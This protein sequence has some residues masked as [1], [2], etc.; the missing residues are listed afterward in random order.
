MA[1][2]GDINVTGKLPRQLEE[3]LEDKFRDGY[4]VSPS[5]SVQIRTF[6]PFFVRGAVRAPG[7]FRFEIDMNVDR[8]IAISGGLKDRA[9]SSKWFIIRENSSERIPANGD[10]PLY[11]GDILEIEESLF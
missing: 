1:L 4:L 11:P 5:V 6:R 7:S 2:I 10:S 9:S 3:E 8:A